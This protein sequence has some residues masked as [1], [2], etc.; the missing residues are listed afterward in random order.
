MYKDEN[1]KCMSTKH[2]GEKNMFTKKQN[3][4]I[5]LLLVIIL[6]ITAILPSNPTFTKSSFQKTKTLSL[7]DIYKIYENNCDAIQLISSNKKQ[8]IYSITNYTVNGEKIT[9]HIEASIDNIG[10]KI[11]KISENNK[12]DIVTID[13]ANR[14]Y[15]DKKSVIIENLE[16]RRNSMSEATPMYGHRIY[17]Q[18]N[19]PYGKRSDYTKKVLPS[20]KSLHT[21]NLS[22]ML[23]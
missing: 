21:Q 18:K 20:K 7:K 4:C 14:I 2:Q 8:L 15:V 19:A 12:Q 17:W 3:N 10:Q 5:A 23:Q 9:S 6:N 1:N 11:L 13:T 22:K 16:N